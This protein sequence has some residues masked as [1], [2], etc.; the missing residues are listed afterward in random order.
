[1]YANSPR[2]V[3][4]GEFVM[5]S[6]TR[7]FILEEYFFKRG[8]GEFRFDVINLSANAEICTLSEGFPLEGKLSPEVSEAD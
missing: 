5:R 6:V 8:A 7:S 2:L 3:G 1:M 4:C